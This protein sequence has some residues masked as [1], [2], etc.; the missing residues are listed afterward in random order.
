MMSF[1]KIALCLTALFVV[2]FG[3]ASAHNVVGT[4]ANASNV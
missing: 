4:I 2:Y 1:T 3:C